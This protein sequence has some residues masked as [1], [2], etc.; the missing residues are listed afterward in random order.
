[1]D[2]NI[3]N[4]RWRMKFKVGAYGYLL[5]SYILLLPLR[6]KITDWHEFFFSIHVHLMKSLSLVFRPLEAVK[7]NNLSLIRFRWRFSSLRHFGHTP[8]DDP[9]FLSIVDKPPKLVKVGRKHNPGV[10]L[11]GYSICYI[12]T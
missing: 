8:A 12:A 2:L 10:I 5:T 3:L 7:R 4:L 1:M 9:N 6:I 11:L